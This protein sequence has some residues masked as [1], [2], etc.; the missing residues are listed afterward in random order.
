L[1]LPVIHLD[2]EYW[3]PDWAKPHHDD[4]VKKQEHLISQETWIADCIIMSNLERWFGAAD[5]IVF[6]D[7]NRFVCIASVLK[8][9]R[10][11]RIG[12]PK[13]LHEPSVFSK[14]FLRYCN[15]IWKYK[16]S[17]RPIVLETQFLFSQ[18]PFVKIKTRR[19]L[20]TLYETIASK[21]GETI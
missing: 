5:L 10:S 7:Y 6:L 3:Q 19:E 15:Y 20:R 1:N 21:G 16:R 13:Y 18:K 4:W 11:K 9:Q 17:H 12:F 2:N 14:E 8:R